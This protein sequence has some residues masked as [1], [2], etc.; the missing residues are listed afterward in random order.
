MLDFGGLM[1]FPL[2]GV[3]EKGQGN[4]TLALGRASNAFLNL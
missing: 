3:E 4:E 2:F 1:S